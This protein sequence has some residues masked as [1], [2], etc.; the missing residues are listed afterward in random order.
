MGGTTGAKNKISR[1]CHNNI[2]IK[3]K[4]LSLLHKPFPINADS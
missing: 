4:K 1:V 3:G 2:A